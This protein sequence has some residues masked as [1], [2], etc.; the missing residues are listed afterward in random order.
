V[1][2][3]A[4][5]ELWLDEPMPCILMQYDARSDIAYWLYVQ[6]YFARISG[7]RMA[8]AGDIIIVHFQTAR[9]GFNIMRQCE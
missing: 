7:F 8:E 6:A 3:G 2:K 5:L 1:I 9:V 4:D